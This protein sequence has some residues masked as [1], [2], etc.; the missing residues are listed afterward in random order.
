MIGIS[1]LLRFEERITDS[2]K[3]GL[4]H[5]LMRIGRGKV[6]IDAPLRD[7]SRWQ[8]GGPADVLVEPST[9]ESVRACLKWLH[10]AGVP[11]I[12]IGDGSNILF[13]DAGVRAVVMRLGRS[14]SRYGIVG[15]TAWAEAGLFVPQFIHALG[16]A[17]LSGAEHAI[18]IPGT[19]GGLVMMNGG[20]MRKGIGERL[21][22]VH[23]C[24][25]LGTAFTWTQQECEFRYRGSR[26]QDAGAVVL[27]AEFAFDRGDPRQ[28]R[29]EMLKIMRDRN[30]KFPR[31]LPNCGSV[32]VSDPAMYAIVGP[33]GKAI[34]DVGLKGRRSGN[35][36]ISPLHANFFVN[37]GGAGSNDILRL[38][39]LA[40]RLVHERTGFWMESEV[41]HIGPD[42]LI[43][44]AHEVAG[45][46]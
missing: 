39:H 43:R 22:Q 18:G 12:V 35:A 45:K 10:G 16:N 8:I 31:E 28:M 19:L 14:L 32:F 5:D 1:T 9:L 6:V 17:G 46:P 7:Y 26:L 40:R 42:G 4:A 24:D 27:S 2:A 38:I 29:R 3:R 41:R 23:C 13:D 34:E 33:P 37:L 36:Q 25:M 44:P 20:S 30:A 11:V 21:T 15:M